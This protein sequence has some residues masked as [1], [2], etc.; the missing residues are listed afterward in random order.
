MLIRIVSI[1]FP[2]FA[3]T[4]LGYFVGRRMKPELSHANK[5]NMDV[6]VPALVFGALVSK[7]FRIG[8]YLPLLFA[9]V[10]IIVGSGLAGWLEVK[11]VS[12][13]TCSAPSV[14]ASGSHRMRL[15]VDS[16]RRSTLITR[17]TGSPGG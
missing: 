8:E 17:A 7:D 9:T 10:V 11:G 4:A 6:F 14:R 16:A 1:L 3:I 13:S 5:L 15:K 2:L 12:T